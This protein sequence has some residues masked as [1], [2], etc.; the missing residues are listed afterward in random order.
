MNKGKG[1]A[2]DVDG[3]SAQSQSFFER[4]GT[5]ARGLAR[6]AVMPGGSEV[7]ATLE[8]SLAS[9]QKGASSSVG[10]RSDDFHQHVVQDTVGA[11]S[12][13]QYATS[14][15][16]RSAPR[17]GISGDAML[18]WSQQGTQNEHLQQPGV[19]NGLQGFDTATQRTRNPPDEAVMQTAWDTSSQVQ[20]SYHVGSMNA[21]DGA[22]V[23]KLLSDPSFQP[24]FW[25]EEDLFD[26]EKP[27]S[28]TAEEKA[29]SDRFLQAIGGMTIP[30][31][32]LNE[33]NMD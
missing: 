22:D 4:V 25:G 26:E 16:L 12:S 32:P 23:V 1:K 13:S 20:T 2:P 7:N 33:A 29:I 27:M 19:I 31:L 10:S 6:D 14:R 5:S 30:L 21:T 18:E 9:S 24:E 28:I 15:G 3:D 8:S 17:E 11:P